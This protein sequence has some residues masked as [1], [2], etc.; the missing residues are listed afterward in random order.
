MMRYQISVT[1]IVFFI[2]FIGLSGCTQIDSSV[3]KLESNQ[4]SFETYPEET[5]SIQD[6]LNKAED[7]ESV[8]YEMVMSMDMTEIGTQQATMKIWK[9]GL[10]LKEMITSE[11]NGITSTISLIQRPDGTYLYDEE[12]GYYE[13]EIKEALSYLSFIDYFDT[14]MVMLYIENQ[15]A[16]DL[17][18]EVIDGK[19]ATIIDYAPSGDDESISVMLWMWNEK[20]LPLKAIVDMDIEEMSM[21]IEVSFK[22][23]SFNDI[24]DDIF[25]IS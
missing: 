8:Y 4:S 2:V 6:I 13:I 7:I 3:E 12:L 5:E 25:D 24:S 15:T 16:M 19:E 22:N 11:F 18:T 23:Y 1:G 10:Y 17:E 14:D 20:G 21:Y 9:K